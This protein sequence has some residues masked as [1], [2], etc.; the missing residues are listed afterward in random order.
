MENSQCTTHPKRTPMGL[1]VAAL[2]LSL[3]LIS[4]TYI[5]GN[6]YVAGKQQ[7]GGLI[8]VTGSAKKEIRSDYAVWNGTFAVQSKLLKDTYATIKVQ[9]ET[10][11]KYLLSKGITEAELSS[12]AVI[13]SINYAK[14][15]SGYQTNDIEGYRLSQSVEV[16]SSNVDLISKISKESTELIDKGVEF[17]SGQPQ[18]FYTKIAEMK[19]NMLALATQDAT[20]RSEQI[21]SNSKSQIKSLKK[22]K[23]G[24]FQIMPKNSNNVT[25]S[26][27]DDT[28]SIDKEIMAVLNCEFTT[29][30]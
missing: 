4:A 17:T 24:V 23:M 3:G 11:R 27:V 28:S 14:N 6:S 10:V 8:S 25:D 22:A 15:P 5:G 19:V 26:G 2:L 13:T 1:M 20:N 16:K 21:A 9:N 7:E 30:K 12:L 18:Y 29:V